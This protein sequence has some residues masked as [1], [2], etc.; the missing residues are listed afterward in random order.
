MSGNL[1]VHNDKLYEHKEEP[2][3]QQHSQ[4]RLQNT[5]LKS[6]LFTWTTLNI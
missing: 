1:K 2:T 5:V 6:K 3:E 4:I